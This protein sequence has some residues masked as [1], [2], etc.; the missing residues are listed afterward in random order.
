MVFRFWLAGNRSNR[1]RFFFDIL[2]GTKLVTGERVLGNVCL[3]R[4]GVLTV[5]NDTVVVVESCICIVTSLGLT[6]NSRGYL[7]VV[8]KARTELESPETITD[9]RQTSQILLDINQEVLHLFYH[10]L[11]LSHLLGLNEGEE[12][13]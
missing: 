2:Y 11:D 8:L 9:T 5:L 7:L 12:K 1:Q 13:Y 3:H 4:L 6:E 10:I